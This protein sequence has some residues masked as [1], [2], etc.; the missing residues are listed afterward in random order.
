M[1]ILPFLKV[2]KQKKYNHPHSTPGLKK[3]S[4][5]LT[6]VGYS[7]KTPSPSPPPHSPEEGEP[8]QSRSSVGK[9]RVRTRNLLL[10]HSSF[11][12]IF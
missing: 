10:T 2:K 12:I 4:Q 5:H 9:F 6:R 3:K 1:E 8:S 7:P 11:L